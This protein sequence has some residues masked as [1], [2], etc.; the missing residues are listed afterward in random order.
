MK[1]ETGTNV[2]SN[3]DIRYP[4]VRLL[5]Q[6]REFIGVVSSTE[7]RQQA[8]SLGMDLI[9]LSGGAIPPV[10][11]IGKLDKYLYQKKKALKEQK[12]AHKQIQMKEIQIRP[13]IAENDLNRKLADGDKFLAA[14]DRLHVIIQYKGRELAR[15]D[16]TNEKMMTIISNA[17][18]HGKIDGVPSF[19][20]K[21]TV[22]NVVPK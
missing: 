16:A 21:R 17:L 9:E 11:F 8:E 6:H 12:K 22:I 20:G 15:V 5:D 10:C 18:P 4:E 1:A 14:G 13:N 19:S 3:A 2:K 7:A